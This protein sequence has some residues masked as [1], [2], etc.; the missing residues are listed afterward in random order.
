MARANGQVL[1]FVVQGCRRG[2]GRPAALWSSQQKCV[3]AP[4][5]TVVAPR[6]KLESIVIALR[7]VPGCRDRKCKQ[8]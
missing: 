7:H 1:R 3:G 2:C 8:P 4:Q 6:Y 5:Q